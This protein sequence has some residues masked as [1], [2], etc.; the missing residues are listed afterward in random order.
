MGSKDGIYTTVNFEDNEELVDNNHSIFKP[1]RKARTKVSLGKTKH[2]E[3]VELPFC[4]TCKD[5]EHNSASC[6]DKDCVVCKISF[7][8]LD[9]A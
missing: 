8:N 4:G 1:T 6:T 3:L 7:N 2:H 5:E 9:H